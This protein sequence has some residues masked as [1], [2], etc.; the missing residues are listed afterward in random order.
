MKPSIQVTDCS[1]GSIVDTMQVYFK[2]K[3]SIN[4]SILL[5][6]GWWRVFKSVTLVPITIS[7][8]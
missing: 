6:C 5:F 1:L 3:K 7:S 4:K 2:Q 8:W